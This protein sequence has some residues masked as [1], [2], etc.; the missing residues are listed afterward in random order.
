MSLAGIAHYL[1]P[2]QLVRIGFDWICTYVINIF[3]STPST[4]DG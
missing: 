1:S 4:E 2:W 3:V